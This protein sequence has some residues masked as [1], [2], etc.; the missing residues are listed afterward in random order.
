VVHI[1][2]KKLAGTHINK[3]LVAH[4]IPVFSGR[5]SDNNVQIIKSIALSGPVLKY[6]VYKDIKGE[7]STTNRRIDDLFRKGYLAKSGERKTQ[8]GVLETRYGLTWIGL[9]A[10]LAINEVRENALEIM[11]KHLTGLNIKSMQDSGFEFET[12]FRLVKEF[13][14]SI[15]D[16]KQIETFITV[17]FKGYLH[18]PAP[19]L[20]SLA[21]VEISYFEIMQWIMVTLQYSMSEIETLP[22]GP[23]I[24]AMKIIELFDNPDILHLTQSLFPKISEHYKEG[25]ENQYRFLVHIP[26]EI[27]TIIQGL[28]ADDKPS[29]KVK[30]FLEN[31]LSRTSFSLEVKG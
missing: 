6:D 29:V 14:E 28:D 23:P 16:S 11:E 1:L 12:L 4:K 24:P 7:Y 8:R 3:E 17:L 26:S 25:L 22:D 21:S 15:L 5:A 30:E 10:S 31:E 20:D 19:T 13:F 27:G 2:S 9:I 18:S